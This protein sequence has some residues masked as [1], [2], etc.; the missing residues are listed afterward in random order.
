[1]NRTKSGRKI[2]FGMTTENGSG[3]KLPV[4]SALLLV[5]NHETVVNRIQ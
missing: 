1:M 2:K 5:I 4:E 3:K